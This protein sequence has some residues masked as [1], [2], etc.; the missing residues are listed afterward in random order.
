M[1]FNTEELNKILEE[2]GF[3]GDIVSLEDSQPQEMNIDYIEEWELVSH[4]I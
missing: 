2:E 1:Y 4:F 3:G